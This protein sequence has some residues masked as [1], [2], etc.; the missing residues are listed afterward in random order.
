MFV[1]WH[2]KL[3]SLVCYILIII[4][5]LRFPLCLSEPIRV[6]PTCLRVRVQLQYIHKKGQFLVPSQSSLNM[7]PWLVWLRNKRTMMH[8][9]WTNK[10]ALLRLATQYVQKNIKKCIKIVFMNGRSLIRSVYQSHRKYSLKKSINFIQTNTCA[11][12]RNIIFTCLIE[13][14]TSVII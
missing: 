10:A 5:V 1:S 12:S 14:K 11:T 8:G 6:A 7:K 4:I 13:F 3:W 9:L 2:T